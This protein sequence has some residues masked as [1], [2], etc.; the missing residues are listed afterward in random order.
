MAVSHEKHCLLIVISWQDGGVY[1]LPYFM[2]NKKHLFV[3]MDYAVRDS[4]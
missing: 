2:I 3:D 4:K 1:P